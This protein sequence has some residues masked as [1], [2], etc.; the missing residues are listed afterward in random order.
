MFPYR[1]REDLC[2]RVGYI[3]LVE[4]EVPDRIMVVRRLFV[5]VNQ[6]HLLV[7]CSAPPTGN[8]LP[9]IASYMIAFPHIQSGSFALVPAG[10]CVPLPVVPYQFMAEDGPA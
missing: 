10:V 4:V 8:M 9:L 5:I 3:L 6:T 7:W 2:F 1:L